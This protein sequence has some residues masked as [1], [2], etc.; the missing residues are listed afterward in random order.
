MYKKKLKIDP[1]FRMPELNKKEYVV[2][3]NKKISKDPFK[4]FQ[5]FNFKTSY[6]PKVR[7]SFS[8]SISFGAKM[9]KIESWE[10]WFKSIRSD[11]KM[12]EQ[13]R[14]MRRNLF[15]SRPPLMPTVIS[16]DVVEHNINLVNSSVNDGKSPKFNDMRSISH[17]T[18][19]FLRAISR[20]PIP[21][22]PADQYMVEHDKEGKTG[23]DEYIIPV[24]PL[25]APIPVNAI[26]TAPGPFTKLTEVNQKR[27]QIKRKSDVLLEKQISTQGNGGRSQMLK[28]GKRRKMNIRKDG[29]QPRQ[30]LSVNSNN[31][32]EVCIREDSMSPSE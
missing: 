8:I 15:G 24:L 2:Q 19:S 9:V 29:G 27:R 18:P 21:L 26:S 12:D 23:Q 17:I 5:L 22:K 20:E 3:C 11:C 10:D 25:V 28:K 7:I 16:Q 30:S 32:P 4:L 6:K 14:E 1:D 31:N 13:S